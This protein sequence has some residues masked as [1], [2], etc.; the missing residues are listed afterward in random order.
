MIWEQN[1]Q[2][3]ATDQ[4]DEYKA[5]CS[6]DYPYF[7]EYYKMIEWTKD[8]VNKKSLTLTQK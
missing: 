2:K 8:K 1:N 5:G 6:P 3:I 7:S 4:V